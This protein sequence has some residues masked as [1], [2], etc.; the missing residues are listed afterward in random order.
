MSDKKKSSMG[1][2]ILSILEDAKYE[3]E[4]ALYTPLVSI[5]KSSLSPDSSTSYE[6]VK[7]ALI[8]DDAEKANKKANKIQDNVDIGKAKQSKAD[9][10]KLRAERLY[11]KANSLKSNKGN[12]LI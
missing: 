4:A 9:K 3:A 11:N 1:E 6:E 8:E 2:K 5:A 7:I 12:D 10:E